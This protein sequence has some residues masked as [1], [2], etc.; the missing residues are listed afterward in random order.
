MIRTRSYRRKQRIKHIN[1]RIYIAENCYYHYGIN[2]R[3]RGI[4][5]KGKVHCSC[6]M[7]SMHTRNKGNRKSYQPSYNWKHSDMLKIN[8]MEDKEK[9]FE[10]FKNF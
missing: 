10:I 3:P 2:E 7:C 1:H 6:S 5:D 4:F 9:E 8:T